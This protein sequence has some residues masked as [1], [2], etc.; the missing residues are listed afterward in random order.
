[1]TP[2]GEHLETPRKVDLA[3]VARIAR[4]VDLRDIR[5]S[6]IAAASARRVQGNLEPDLSHECEAIRLEIPN[7]FEVV[8]RYRFSVKTGGSEVASA[9][10]RYV[11]LYELE[12]DE[13]IPEEGLSDFAFAN[14]TYHSWPFVR[15]LLYDL[16]AKMGYPPYTL[17]VLKFNPK[18]PRPTEEAPAEAVKAEAS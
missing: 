6:E 18:A 14:G 12:G 4:R 13:D 2:K 7:L 16:T 15:Q 1:V 8:C 11:L 5:L 10:F 17:P 9:M 3:A